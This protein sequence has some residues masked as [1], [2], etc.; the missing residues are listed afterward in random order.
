[1]YSRSWAAC[2]QVGLRPTSLLQRCGEASYAAC[3]HLPPAELGQVRVEVLLSRIHMVALLACA[4][5]KPVTA[6]QLLTAAQQAHTCDVVVPLAMPHQEERLG[7][8]GRQQLQVGRR[9]D[10]CERSVSQRLSAAA[11]C[12]STAL[13]PGCCASSNTGKDI[14]QTAQFQR[15]QCLFL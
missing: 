7:V 13:V 1:M 5:I 11:H 6:A 2:E 10:A 12:C 4:H 14:L 15:E 3:T 9:L 8:P